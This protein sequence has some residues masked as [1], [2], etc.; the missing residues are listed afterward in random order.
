MNDA[1]SATMQSVRGSEE[2]AA[3]VVIPLYNEEQILRQNLAILAACFD[4]VVG[5]GKWHFILVENGSTDATSD[6]VDAAVKRWPPSQA[7]HLKESNYGTALKTG[8]RA[9]AAKWVYIV[10][11]EQWDLPFIAW[12]WRERTRYDV[13]MASKRADPSISRQQYYRRLLSCGLNGLL[14]LFVQ[15]TGTDTHGPKLLARE[16]L[17]PIIDA[18]ELD[19]GQYDTELILRA[20]RSGKRIVEVPFPYR[21]ARPNRNWMV[22]KIVWNLV[23]L[24]RLVEVLKK[25][26]SEGPQR[27]YRLCREDV[28]EG[29]RE[30]LPEIAELDNV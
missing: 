24:K 13:M 23:A 11:I 7:I 27:Y 16:P 15:F 10:D 30:I 12:S 21:E 25:V 17:K 3:S 14:Q 5:A 2:L 9:A 28:L 8:L 6:L 26:P 29:C 19:R 20:I 18:C 4:R 1:A 22:K